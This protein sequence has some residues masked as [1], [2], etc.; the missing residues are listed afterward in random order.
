MLKETVT[1][2][3]KGTALEIAARQLYYRWF[4]KFV[5]KPLTLGPLKLSFR[6]PTAIEADE[7]A[8]FGGERDI[9]ERFVQELPPGSAVWD[10]GA[11]IGMWALFCGAKLGDKG[12]VIAFEPDPR[13]R[14]FLERNIRLNNSVNVRIVTCALGQESGRT[15][16]FTGTRDS[17]VSGLTPKKGAHPTVETASSVQVMRADEVVSKGVAPAPYAAKIDVEGA[18]LA[19]LRGFGKDAWAVLNLLA[20]EVHPALLARMGGSVDE[21]ESILRE[22]GFKIVFSGARRTETHW[23]CKRA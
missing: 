15:N 11:N 5:R 20:I 23:L 4:G 22:H 21:L 13:A 3:I 18:E 1:R 19:V 6:V 14:A 10:I 7:L 9:L 2:T 8:T 16:F 12:T 17:Q